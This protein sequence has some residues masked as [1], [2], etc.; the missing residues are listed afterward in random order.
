MHCFTDYP[1]DAPRSSFG[2]SILDE[3]YTALPAL[4]RRRG[5]PHDVKMKRHFPNNRRS[6][7]G[8]GP[9]TLFA[10]L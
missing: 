9:V 7:K 1:S 10:V 6:S 3:T 8:T 4:P 5:T 2:A